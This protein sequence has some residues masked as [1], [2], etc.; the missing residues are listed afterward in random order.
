MSV[1]AIDDTCKR[2]NP[3]ELASPDISIPSIPS[4]M[5]IFNFLTSLMLDNDRGSD[6]K[7]CW[8]MDRS[9]ESRTIEVNSNR[10]V[11]GNERDPKSRRGDPEPNFN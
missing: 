3:D 1:R 6:G 8:K 2:K 4:P 10:H 7:A 9:K 5:L 11:D